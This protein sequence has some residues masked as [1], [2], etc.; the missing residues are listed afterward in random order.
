MAVPARLPSITEYLA[1]END[2]QDRHEY[3]R[4]EIFAMVGARR[5]HGLVEGNLFAALKL[6]LKGG[7]CRAF[8]E[9][10][11][12]QVADNVVFYPDVFVTCD[13]RDLKTDMIFHH[14]KLVIEVLS[15]S[16]QSFDRGLKFAAY[17]ELASLQEYV[18]V[19]PDT[20]RVEVYR[21]NERALFELHDQTGTDGLY[22]ACIEC[23]VPMAEVFDGL[24]DA[25]AGEGG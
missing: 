14:P 5:V 23:H 17:R 16:T 9:G 2:Q 18:L 1:W 22:L 13:E 6:H 25:Q 7:P 24:A 12:V 4:G 19:D 21:R 15:D 20:R 10:M 3:Y 8:V 11:K